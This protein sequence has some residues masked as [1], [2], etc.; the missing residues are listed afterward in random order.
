MSQKNLELWALADRAMVAVIGFGA[1]I[2]Y[3]QLPAG[4]PP[5]NI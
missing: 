5:K 1:F 2:A 4:W 3:A